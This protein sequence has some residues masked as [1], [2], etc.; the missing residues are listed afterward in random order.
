ME[1][2]EVVE[3]VRAELGRGADVVI[4]ALGSTPTTRLAVDLADDGGRVVLTG[5]AP[6]GH[7]LDSEITKIVRRKIQILGSF[8]AVASTAMPA[9]L[10]MAERGELDLEGLIT[11]RFE[12]AET[13]DAYVALDERR[14]LGRSLIETN[15]GL[16]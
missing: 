3:A 4:E 10:A 11:Q 1:H 9:V 2:A 14:I 15:P 8:G 5:I 7:T 13:D 16:E 12:F 6:M